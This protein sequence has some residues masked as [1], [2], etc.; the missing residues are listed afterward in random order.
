MATNYGKL[1]QVPADPEGLPPGMVAY[2]LVTGDSTPWQEVAPPAAD[3]AWFIAVDTEGHIRVCEREPRAMCMAGMDVW[4]IEH[5][6]PRDDIFTHR[7]TGEKV[8]LLKIED[9]S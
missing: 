8:E 2:I 5:P 7:W 4:R 3:G 6:G 9:G 1:T